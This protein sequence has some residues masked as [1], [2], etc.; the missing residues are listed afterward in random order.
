MSQFW[1][2]WKWAPGFKVGTGRE[3]DI[4]WAEAVAIELGLRIAIDSPPSSFALS[5]TLEQLRGCRRLRIQAAREVGQPIAC[6]S[7]HPFL[8]HRAGFAAPRSTQFSFLAH[9]PSHSNISLSHFAP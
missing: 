9:P 8:L 2:V 7:S 1:A 3:F 5:G 4:G 6:L